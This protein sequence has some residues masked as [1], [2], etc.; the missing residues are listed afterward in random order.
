MYFFKYN[1]ISS[2]LNNFFLSILAS[3]LYFV[4]LLITPRVFSLTQPDS[5]GYIDFANIRSSIYP[6]IIDVF[7]ILQVSL[8]KLVMLQIF[9]FLISVTYFIYQL[10]N[11]KINKLI[12]LT[13]YL[14]L[15]LN[16]YYNG[17]HFTILTESLSF[18]LILV[19]IGQLI[20]FF[21]LKSKL[22]TTII[23]S[24]ITLMFCIKPATA[25]IFAVVL[26]AVIFT[27]YSEQKLN[28][29]IFVKS[30]FFPILIFISIENLIFFNNHGTKKTVLERHFFGKAVMIKLLHYQK[31][32]FIDYVPNKKTDIFIRKTD[33][34]F[35]TV[36]GFYGKC[37]KLER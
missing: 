9:I 34:Y 32:K 19:L 6:S 13:I 11:F 7:Q 28:I 23:V 16:I 33:T 30:I 35:N 18:S 26:I 2:R 36:N 12:I 1:L 29:T 37:L 3:L 5:G 10:L 15:F 27:L 24:I 31:N 4:I 14:S 25:P 20:S 21:H 8:E 17:F 22:D